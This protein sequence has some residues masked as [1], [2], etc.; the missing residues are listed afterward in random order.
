MSDDG[1]H[2]EPADEVEEG[3]P[4]WM[5]TFADLMSLLLTFFVLLLS[6]ANMDIQNFQ[7]AL[8]SVKEAMGVQFE[9][10]GDRMGLTTSIVEMS[11]EESTDKLNTLDQQVTQLFK[12]LIAAR[13]VE[14]MVEVELGSRGIVVRIQNV[15]LFEPGGTTLREAAHAPLMIVA[16]GARELDLP[17]W[18][19]GHTDNRPISSIRF[20]SNW[21]LSAGRATSALRFLQDV[22]K[23][24]KYR[25]H[26]AG[27]AD[28]RPIRSNT[29][30]DGRA[31]NRRVEFLF[32]SPSDRKEDERRELLYRAER[33][34]QKYNLPPLELG[35]AAEE[36]PASTTSTTT[37]ALPEGPRD[38][39]P[40]LLPAIDPEE[41]DVPPLL[42][43]VTWPEPR[44]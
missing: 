15:V 38:I 35:S 8:G 5:A 6:F 40:K 16:D 34:R 31:E 7:T 23:V 39:R 28:T 19:E 36:A 14:G 4:A 29:T 13:Q 2:F 32:L 9:H 22:G 43:A 41:V 27:Y 42:P 18:I 10:P 44:P 30:A 3:A 24:R 26:I 20:P 21:E 33:M 37:E 1:H 11:K 25:M 12:N 17:L